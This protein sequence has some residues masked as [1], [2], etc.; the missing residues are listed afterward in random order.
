MN[1]YLM[2]S[3]GWV[4]EADSEEEATLI[5]IDEVCGAKTIKEYKRYCKDVHVDS[6]IN[7]IELEGENA[8]HGINR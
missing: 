6:E 5:F 2:E 3:T 4:Y 8:L 7:W 1:K